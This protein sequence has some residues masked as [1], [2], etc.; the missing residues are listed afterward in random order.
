MRFQSVRR[1]TFINVSPNILRYAAPTELP[2]Q[3]SIK[4]SLRTNSSKTIL[5]R[6]VEIFYFKGL[7]EDTTAVSEVFSLSLF[8]RLG[9]FLTR[10]N[11][12]QMDAQVIHINEH[13]CAKDCRL[14]LEIR[15]YVHVLPCHIIT[16]IY[17]FFG[18]YQACIDVNI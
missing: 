6:I 12:F 4:R 7:F 13:F 3:G 15:P 8:E 17:L 5:T 16:K 18:V 11:S 14:C 2:V 10:V 9:T 1:I